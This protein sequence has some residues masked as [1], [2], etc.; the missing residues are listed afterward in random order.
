MRYRSYLVLV[1]LFFVT[2]N[3]LLWRAEFGV[4]GHTGTLVPA[5]LVW[6][7]LLTSP[8]NSFLEIQHRGVK[9]G[10]AHW[11]P[12]IGEEFT[13]DS[14][15]SE[16][17]PPE[18]MIRQPTGYA[19]DFDGHVSLDDLSRLRFTFNLKL[20]TNQTWQD[21][22]LKLTIKPLSWELHSSA[23]RQ[24]VRFITEEDAERFERTYSF[25]EL[26]NPEKI[27]RE[28]GGPALPATLAALGL[29][30]SQ[31][32]PSSTGIS[33]TWEARNDRVKIGSNYIRVHRLEA[34]LF[35][36]F[37]AVLFV[38]PVGEILRMELPDDIVLTNDA[39][40]NL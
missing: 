21:L 35:D 23:V 30:L 26:R 18:G 33:L 1:T 31:V 22:I 10:R 40:T 28:L 13:V 25:A 9:I 16:D 11:A 12:S 20:D 3:V 17:L 5:E 29:P 8:D 19:L 7:K 15:T 24:D 39:L 32:K 27:I 34:R 38:S 36:R 2:M 14:V 37:K 6:D 4:R